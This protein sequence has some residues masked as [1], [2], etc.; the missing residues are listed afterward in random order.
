[1]SQ[2]KTNLSINRTTLVVRANIKAGAKPP[3]PP[4]TTGYTVDICF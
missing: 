1:M 2:P 4:P 3:P